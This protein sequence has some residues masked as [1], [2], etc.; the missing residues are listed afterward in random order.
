MTVSV[1]DGKVQGR[2]VLT[3]SDN[4]KEDTFNA[5]LTPM[6][7][8]VWKMDFK[9]KKANITGTGLFKNGKF[10]GDYR[11]KK[12]LRVDRGKWILQKN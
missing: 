4:I 8:G 12:L 9:C 3:G 2:V 11:Y 10:V 6:G 5:D 1:V 7:A